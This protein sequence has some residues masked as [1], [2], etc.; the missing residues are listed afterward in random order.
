MMNILARILSHGFAIAVVVILAVGYIYRGE[1]FPG[2]ELPAFLYPGAPA[3]TE[4]EAPAGE[5]DRDA[6]PPVEIAPAEVAGEP[7][8]EQ[9]PADTGMDAAATS[10]AGEPT[11]MDAPSP[12]VTDGEP[13]APDAPPAEIVPEEP[14]AVDTVAPDAAAGEPELPAVETAAPAEAMPAEPEPEA[15]AGDTVAEDTRPADSV[16]G[17]ATDTIAP[18]A[19]HAGATAPAMDAA[20]SPGEETTDRPYQLLAAAREAFWLHNYAEAETKY[21]DLIAL[22][23]DNPDGYGELGNMYFSQGNWEQA[24]DAYFSAGKKLIKAGRSQQAEMLVEVIRGLNGSQADELES[25]VKA[26]SETNR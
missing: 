8:P 24:A 21:R 3:P 1:L 25:L 19:D 6:P 10:T 5:V 2:M 18:A 12:E 20:A 13:A 14:A 16:P 7:A 22:E 15:F 4:A 26:A 9:A 17:T 11:P 23:P